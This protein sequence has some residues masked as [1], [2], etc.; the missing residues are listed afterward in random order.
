MHGDEPAWYRIP[1]SRELAAQYLLLYE[2]SL[3]YGLDLTDQINI[4]KSATRLTIT[5]DTLT[6]REF[7]GL[8]ADAEAWLAEHA[9]PEM[10]GE[11]TGLAVMFSY[12]TERN[13]RSMLLGT[14]LAFVMISLSLI[15]SLRSVKFG[16]V[17]LVPNLVPPIMAFGI[18][19][20]TVGE[21]G[22]SASVVT[23]TCLGIIVDDTVHF[24]SKYLRAR[25]EEG[26]G[27]EDAVRYA[28]ST[29]GSALWI[30]SAVLICGFCVLIF[31][32]MRFMSTMGKLNAIA[33]FFALG[34]DFLLLPPLLMAL[35][36]SKNA[37][38]VAC[39]EVTPSLVVDGR[40]DD[41]SA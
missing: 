4:D 40:M 12:M 7:K 18:W 17:S 3:P 9:P 1:E 41:A 33:I 24:L 16:L 31:S 21:V 15:I 22:I 14:L 19:A 6:T 10:R 38:A 28:Y 23:A 39:P 27:P 30:T 32:P 37:A 36:R 8:K 13:I 35:D 2:I 20:V 34:A 26:L 29:V 5:A 25:R 11:G